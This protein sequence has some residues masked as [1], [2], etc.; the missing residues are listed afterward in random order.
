V[1]HTTN[2]QD[3]KAEALLLHFAAEAHRRKWSYDRGLDDDG[4]PIKS[5]AF[6]ALHRL[7]E[8]MRTAL[9]EL[10]RAPAVLPSVVVSADRATLRDR[11]ADTVMP[12]LLNFSDEESARIN[13]AE[14]ADALLAVLPAPA[15][16]CICGHSKQQHFEDAC[17]TE[18]TGCNCGDYLEPQ[19]AAEVIDRWRQAALQART[20]DRA[21]LLR[22]AEAPTD[23]I[24]GH[25]Q[26]EAIAAAVWEK[27]G[28]SD[29]GLIIDDPRN[30]AV[31]AL[32]AVLPA[33]ADRATLSDSDR[34]FLTFALDLAFDRMVSDDGFTAEDAAALEKLRR[35]ADG[36]NGVAAEEQPAETQDG[37]EPALPGPTGEELAGHIAAQPLSVVQAALRILGWPLRFEVVDDQ[38]DP[39]RPAVA[40]QPDTQTREADRG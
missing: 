17:I 29:S 40:E 24:D 34:Q 33:P 3:V 7:G 32:A 39:E 11:I 18:I 23:W 14:V 28:R 2:P 5:E 31:A 20:A 38:Q 27:C 21:T 16:V 9:E 30:I 12:F 10:R 6:D 25:P 35:V 15:P 19:D 13:A 26:L 37:E 1:N 22:E 8:E 4:V 36:P